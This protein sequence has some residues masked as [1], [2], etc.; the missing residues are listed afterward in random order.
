MQQYSAEQEREYGK[1]EFYQPQ[2][3]A[4]RVQTE[5]NNGPSFGQRLGLAIT[6]VVTLLL[7][8]IGVMGFLTNEGHESLSWPALILACVLIVTLSGA[9]TAINFIFGYKH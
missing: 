2:A 3:A 8:C 6:S 1:D 4:Q 5:A 7:V 9:I